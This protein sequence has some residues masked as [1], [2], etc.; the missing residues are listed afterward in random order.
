MTKSQVATAVLEP[1]VQEGHEI[2]LD[3]FLKSLKISS[4]NEEQAL[5]PM[6]SEGLLDVNE[7]V[8]DAARLIS[9]LATIIWNID[10][11]S[12]ETRQG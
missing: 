8:S 9:S 11:G 4:Y 1:E 12:S 3:L 10:V 7:E 6:L 5:V 2:S